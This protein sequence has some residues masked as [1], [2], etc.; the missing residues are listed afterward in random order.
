MHGF[1]PTVPLII[2][3]PNQ[4]N[5]IHDRPHA[6]ITENLQG[7]VNY[8]RRFLWCMHRNER[9]SKCINSYHY[10]N[11]TNIF[12]FELYILHLSTKAEKTLPQSQYEHTAKSSPLYPCLAWP[13]KLDFHINNIM[14]HFIP[15]QNKM[16]NQNPLQVFIYSFDA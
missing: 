2:D 3:H 16:T 12:I 9:D 14:I 6:Q 5:F 8:I 10:S 4:L 11:V 15:I 1:D 7:F 13:W